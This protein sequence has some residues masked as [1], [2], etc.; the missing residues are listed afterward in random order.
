M[1]ATNGSVFMIPNYSGYKIFRL[2]FVAVLY[3][4]LYH[5]IHWYCLEDSSHG[6]SI[7]RWLSCFGL[8]F[9]IIH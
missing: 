5:I 2:Q 6:C 9:R 7:R 3:F 8:L 1:K 4:T